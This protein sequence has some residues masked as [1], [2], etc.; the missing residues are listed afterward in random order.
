MVFTWHFFSNAAV[1]KHSL[2]LILF[3]GSG[4]V[5]KFI[6]ECLRSLF[7]ILCNGRSSAGCRLK[8][9]ILWDEMIG[10]ERP[11][12]ASRGLFLLSVLSCALLSVCTAYCIWTL[13]SRCS[14]SPPVSLSLSPFLFPSFLSAL[15]CF[16]CICVLWM[17]FFNACFHM[18]LFS[19]CKTVSLFPF[20]QRR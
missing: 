14:L 10:E 3:L 15:G 19:L 20:K 7:F 8:S 9:G 5:G 18:P 6:Y 12:Q 11:P 4:G 2:R 16:W 13:K 17:V 1:L